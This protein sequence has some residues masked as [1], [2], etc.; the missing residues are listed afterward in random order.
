MIFSYHEHKEIHF[1]IFL[2][3]KKY[4]CQISIYFFEQR[5]LIYSYNK[6]LDGIIFLSIHDIFCNSFPLDILHL[7]YFLYYHF[8]SRMDIKQVHNDIILDFFD[9]LEYYE[10]KHNWNGCDQQLSGTKL[11]YRHINEILNF[12]TFYR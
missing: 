8:F 7:V 11:F 9:S 6:Y 1:F 2:H 5:Q 12:S 3:Q 4:S 10:H